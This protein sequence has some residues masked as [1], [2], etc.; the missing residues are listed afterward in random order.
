MQLD[1]VR[2]INTALNL[3]YKG[4]EK[5]NRGRVAEGYLDLQ[6]AVRQAEANLSVLRTK[7]KMSASLLDI[8][9]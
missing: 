2:A 6:K 1:T 8:Y 3:I 4:A 5:V 7:D 9:A